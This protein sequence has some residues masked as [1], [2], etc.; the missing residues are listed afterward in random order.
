MWLNRVFTH[1]GPV[2][3]IYWRLRLRGRRELVPRTGPLIVAPNHACFLDPWFVSFT[4]PRYVHWL[5]NRAWYEK[6]PAWRRFFDANAVVP[7]DDEPSRTVEVVCAALEEG[8]AIG[9]FPE[10]KISH[11]GKLQRFRAGIARIAAKSGAPVVPVGIRGGFASLPRS[12]TIPKPSRV[13]VHVGEPLRFPGSP[14]AGLPERVAS[15]AFVA[16]LHA[17]VADLSGQNGSP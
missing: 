15:R 17:R 1:S 6:S 11:D 3:G 16:E 13:E 8:R 14:V 12:R 4:F 9:V 2:I 10:G 5:I 7:V